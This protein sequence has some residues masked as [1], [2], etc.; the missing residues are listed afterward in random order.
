MDEKEE[1]RIKIKKLSLDIVSMSVGLKDSNFSDAKKIIS[2]IEKCSLELMSMIDIASIAGAISKMNGSI[3]KEEFESFIIELANFSI[4]HEINKN[5]SIESVFKQF[6]PITDSIEK[7]KNISHGDVLKIKN[8]NNG[9]KRKDFRKSSIFEFIKGHNNA[10]IKDITPNIV[11]CS[12]KTVQREL[13]QLIKE[14]KVQK[15][16]ERR[17]SRYS[18]I[19]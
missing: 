4:N 11:G 15:M 5:V 10:S 12:E 13:I 9:N 3:L 8:I 6:S 19:S 2:N 1:L 16:G 18:I 14:G 17:W 7:T